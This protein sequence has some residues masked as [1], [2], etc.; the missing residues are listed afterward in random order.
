[1]PFLVPGIAGGMKDD[2]DRARALKT[3]REWHGDES[4]GFRAQQMWALF[5]AW[6]CVTLEDSDSFV[7]LNFPLSENRDIDILWGFFFGEN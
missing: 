5:K 1:M 4:T 2:A 6:F 7:K 3:L